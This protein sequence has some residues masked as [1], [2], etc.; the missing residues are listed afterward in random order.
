VPRTSTSSTGSRVFFGNDFDAM[1]EV[2][3]LRAFDLGLLVDEVAL[4][5]QHDAVLRGNLLDRLANSRQQLDRMRQHFL[6]DTDQAVE[7]TRT[8]Q[9]SG[10]IERRLDH[11]QRHALGAVTEH[12]DVAGFD[13]EQALVDAYVA[14]VDVGPDDA[15]ELGL[16]GVV[17]VLALP[18]RIV[19]VKSDQFEHGD[20]VGLSGTERSGNA[21]NC[22]GAGRHLANSSVEPRAGIDVKHRTKRNDRSGSDDRR[23]R[24][25]ANGQDGSRDRL[26]H[27]SGRSIARPRSR[28]GNARTTHILFL[29]RRCIR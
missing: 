19:P 27:C 1:E 25:I 18:E 28:Y 12:M 26:P 21:L 14:E 4:G 24:S 8:D 10:D 17:V 11:R 6:A 2:A 3:E 20:P 5:D 13:R 23:R 16:C 22:I 7:V 9:P 29:Q 15:F